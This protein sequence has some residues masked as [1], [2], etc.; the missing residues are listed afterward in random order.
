MRVPTPAGSPRSR[1]LFVGGLLLLTL[2]LAGVLA[3]QAQ[4]AARSHRA[5]AEKTLREH[6]AVAAWAYTG[7]LRRD[8]YAKAI[9]PGL[10][11]A[12]RAGGKDPAVAMASVTAE[13][14]PKLKPYMA[15]AEQLGAFAGQATQSAIKEIEICYELGCNFYLTKPMQYDEFV[16]VIRLLG[17]VFQI[18]KL[19]GARTQ[20]GLLTET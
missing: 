11:V 5:V 18:V 16:K 4:D 20:P 8:M 19:P 2:A 12:A 14:A 1:S 17:L 10:D 7:V 13:E 6:A 15:L 3:Y 9:G